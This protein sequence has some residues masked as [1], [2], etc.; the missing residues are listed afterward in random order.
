LRPVTREIDR[1][2]LS[3]FAS[4]WT[5]TAKVSVMRDP[6]V[7]RRG[8]DSYTRIYNS[9]PLLCLRRATKNAV[10]RVAMTFAA[11]QV[12]IKTRKSISGTSVAPASPR[13]AQLL[14]ARQA[15]ETRFAKANPPK[16]GDAKLPV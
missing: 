15:A 9:S 11:L 12:L 5:F 2:P 13:R 1:V 3:K 7:S 6:V 10:I 14:F 16:G 8:S 4:A